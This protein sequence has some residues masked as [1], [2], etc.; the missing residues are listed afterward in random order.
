MIITEVHAC[1][2]IEAA[3]ESALNKPTQRPDL[4]GLLILGGTLKVFT[5]T[6]PDRIEV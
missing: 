6:S 1:R 2:E 4:I 3:K 5:D